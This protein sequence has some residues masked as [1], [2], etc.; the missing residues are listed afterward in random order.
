M[1]RTTYREKDSEAYLKSLQEAYPGAYIIPEGGTNALAI[2]GCS[3]ILNNQ[4]HSF[5]YVCCPVGTGGTLSGI[6]ESSREEQTVLGFPALKG[7]FLSD[8]IQK[9]TQKT[10]WKL[11]CDYHFGGYAKMNEALITF[12][13]CLLYTS[14]SPRDRG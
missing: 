6:I 10:N 8:E 1:S 13:N 4:G 7:D 12:I 2:Q 14:P 11:I 3:E 9:W 5:D